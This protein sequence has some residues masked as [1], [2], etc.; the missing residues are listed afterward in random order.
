MTD[1]TTEMA[2]FAFVRKETLEQQPAPLSVA[3]PL[4]WVRQ[5]LLSS[6]LN[7]ALTLI[8][9]YLVIDTVPGM[10]RF[11]FLDAVWSGTSR[12]ACLADKVGRPVGACWAYIAD[13]FQYFIYGS[14]PI[15]QR[16][17]VNIVF[18]MFALGVVWL[19]W[20][21]AP[22]KKL[23][24]FFFFVL[25]PISAYVLLLGG[26]GAERFLGFCLTVTLVLA[27]LYVVLSFVPQLV[28][29]YIGEAAVGVVRELPTW[30]RFSGPKQ[31]VLFALAVFVLLNL[32]AN[33]PGLPR[34]DTGLWGGMT[35]T[36]LIAAVGIVFSL[37]LGVVLALGRRSKLPIIQLLSVIFIEFVR[38]VPLI[39]VLFMANTMLPLFVPQEY[40]PD[41]LLRPLVGVALFAA[42]YMAEVVRGGLQAMPKGQYEGAMSLGLGYW[43]MM[44]LIILPQALRI[45][46]PGIVNTFIGLFKDTTLV[47]IVGIFDFLR[48]I[49]ATLV[50]PTW[51]TP[52]TRA[53][54][55]AFAAVF[56]FL[57]CWGMSRYSIAVEKRLAAGQKR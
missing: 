29:F 14:Y 12:D 45:V 11:Y 6:P 40:S 27:A 43:S 51:A 33:S 54:G 50:D 57:C 5:H 23:G 44:R 46:I 41:R 24:I 52:T 48:T 36:F 18:A 25:L 7:I 42:A 21:N 2:P 37:P 16:W 55:Y 4:A 31:L 22:K 15:A 32:L 17:R 9:L 20:T 10:I 35:V 19:L 1:A 30:K 3:G 53:T 26:P 28:S 13:R 39:T 8:C 47:T 34:V 38:G 49:E 56:Y